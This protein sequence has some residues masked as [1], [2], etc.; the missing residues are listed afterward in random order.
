M[1]TPVPY[2]LTDPSAPSAHSLRPWRLNAFC[3]DDSLFLVEL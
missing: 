3:H 1:D 2:F